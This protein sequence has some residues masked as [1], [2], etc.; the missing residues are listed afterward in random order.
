MDP[1]VLEQK[2]SHLRRILR[3]LGSVVVAFS[4]GVDS[5]FLL[6]VAHETLGDRAVAVT[7]VSPSVPASELAEAK[8]LARRIGSR[9]VLLRSHEVEDERYRENTPMRCYFCRQ[10]TYTL[11]MAFARQEGY[12]AVVDG[13]IADDA[14]DYRPGRQAAREKGVR[15]PL[16]EAGL[17]KAEIRVLSRRMG[18]PTWDKPSMACLSSRIAYGIPVTE[19][20]L[21][22]IERAEQFLRRLGLR[23]LRVRHHGP[24]AR[25]EVEPDDFP[26]LLAHREEIVA[27]LEALGYTYVTMD[28]AGFRSGSMNKAGQ[29]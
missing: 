5:T 6:Q 26:V 4:G 17:T 1:A 3:D 29:G 8:E 27:R 23:Q 15:S 12:A 28:L 2:L 14:D 25:I 21:S 11:M 18:L 7:T 16:L 20:L 22:R 9:H 24:I 10:E 13:A 19:T